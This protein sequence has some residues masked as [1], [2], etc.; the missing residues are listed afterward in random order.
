MISRFQSTQ[1]GKSL[2]PMNIGMILIQRF[3]CQVPNRSFNMY[4]SPPTWLAAWR[5]IA[6]AL[7]AFP[8]NL[9]YQIMTVI[10]FKILPRS[11]LQALPPMLTM[12]DKM[13]PT[14]CKHDYTRRYGNNHGSFAKCQQCNQ[15]FKWNNSTGLWDHHGSRGHSL[16]SRQLPPPSSE[17]ISVPAASKP[18]IRPSSSARTSP[19]S[20]RREFPDPFPPGQRLPEPYQWTNFPDTDVPS[21]S[22]DRRAEQMEV[23]NIV[24]QEDPRMAEATTW[25][26]Q[27]FLNEDGLPGGQ[28]RDCKE[29]RPTSTRTPDGVGRPPD[30]RDRGVLRL[31][32]SGL[33][34]GTEKQLRGQW[35]RSAKLLNNEIQICNVK[36]KP[37]PPGAADLRELFAGEA[38]CSQLAHQY[39][40]NAPTAF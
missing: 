20:H 4:R 39:Q 7:I 29:I 21:S 27:A 34:K 8:K 32:V 35:Q 3:F 1:F 23:F 25:E 24:N 26:Q 13:D 9:I 38:T 18:K 5:S 17:T 36:H 40:L 28:G 22:S 33:K 2:Q 11:V 16:P 15:V 14:T 10:K 30:P 6:M 31:V 37:R 19:T 12:P